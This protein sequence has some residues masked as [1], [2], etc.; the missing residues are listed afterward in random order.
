[1]MNLNFTVPFEQLRVKATVEV[2][3]VVIDVYAV[4]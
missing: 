1:M 2:C 4:S 3:E